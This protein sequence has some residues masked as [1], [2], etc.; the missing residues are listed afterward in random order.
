MAYEADSAKVLSFL[1]NKIKAAAHMQKTSAKTS[2]P[3]STLFAFLFVL[4]LL[5][6]DLLFLS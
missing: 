5:S 6:D 2:A 3:I 1:Q 4:L